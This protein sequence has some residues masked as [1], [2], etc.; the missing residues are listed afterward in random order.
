MLAYKASDNDGHVKMFTIPDD[1]SS[2][3][4]ALTLEH[5]TNYNQWNSLQILDYDNFILAY[6]GS[7]NDGYIKTFNYPQIA[8][9]TLPR[10]S[11]STIAANNS[12]IA[13]T[14]NEP[15]FNTT[16]GS[17]NLEAS[18]FSLA[19]SGGN[20]TLASATPTSIS[21]SGN[22]YTLGMNLSGQA[23][24]FEKITVTPVNDAIF[25]ASDNEANTTQLN[26][27]LLYTSPSPRD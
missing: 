2:I 19:L 25:D 1:G 16:G 8:T 23:S 24:G 17:G 15:V 20:A 27:C 9:S 4:E 22:T 3:T 12:T 18:D 14:F 26:N 21:A 5:E 10:I 11:T 6:E 13:V 7:S